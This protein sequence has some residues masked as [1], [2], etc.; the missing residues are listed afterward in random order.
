MKNLKQITIITII[1]AITFI[2]GGLFT[3]SVS[4]VSSLAQRLAGRILLQVE[5]KGEAWYVDPLNL[6]RYYLGRAQDCFDIMRE[7]GLGINNKDLEQVERAVD[8]KIPGYTIGWKNYNGAFLIDFKY[9]DLFHPLFEDAKSATCSITKNCTLKS[10]FPPDPEKFPVASD[11]LITESQVPLNFGS[12]PG[13]H[14]SSSVSNGKIV[15]YKII[16]VTGVPADGWVTFDA[17]IDG[18][19][20]S[21]YYYSFWFNYPV[22]E[23]VKYDF[24]GKI[25]FEE[26]INSVRFK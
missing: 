12:R 13:Y 8:S 20:E 2:L 26:I 17:V 25:M 16:P 14:Y 3:A 9:P 15:T 10:N 4:A 22:G 23:D 21:G 19:T 24:N 18:P 1:A 7:K 5:N 6:K 11:L